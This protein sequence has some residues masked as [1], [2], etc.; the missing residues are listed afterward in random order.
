M[1]LSCNESRLR[2]FVS[3]A[4]GL[5]LARDQLSALNFWR[6]RGSTPFMHF[7][8]LLLVDGQKSHLVDILRISHS[9]QLVGR[10]LVFFRE[11]STV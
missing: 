4:W 5:P 10:E 6:S 7:G 9:W 11:K 2:I 3:R 8:E 1:V